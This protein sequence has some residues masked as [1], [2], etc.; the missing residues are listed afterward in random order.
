LCENERTENK[1]LRKG[2][3]R[4]RRTT[5]EG[6]KI[7]DKKKG[8]ASHKKCRGALLRIVVSWTAWRW[9]AIGIGGE[10]EWHQKRH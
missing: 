2:S 1:R 3:P 5:R 4:K 6:K 9:T 8:E 10:D 7:R